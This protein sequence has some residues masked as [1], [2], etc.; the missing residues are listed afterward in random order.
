M[1][2]PVITNYKDYSIATYLKPNGNAT[3]LIIKDEKVVG[4]SFV[5]AHSELTSVEKAMSKINKY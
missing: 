3:S 2:N 4:A 5:E 1:N